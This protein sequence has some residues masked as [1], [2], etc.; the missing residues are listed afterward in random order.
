[1]V[2]HIIDDG[3]G[4]PEAELEAVLQPFTGL[5]HRATAIPAEQDSVWR[6]PRS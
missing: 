4:I 2:I 3:P 5:K 1:V 6:L